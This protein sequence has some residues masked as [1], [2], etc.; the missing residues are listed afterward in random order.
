MA[1]LLPNGKQQFE[2][3]AGAPLVGGK[4]YTYDAGTT[5]PRA[6]YQDAAGTIP[7]TNPVILDARGEAT[8][9][10]N[11]TYKIILKDAS[12]VTIW[13]VDNVSAT[14]W[15]NDLNAALATVAAYSADM[16]NATDPAKGAAK[17]G[18][19]NRTVA[20]RLD[21][22]KSVSDFG[23]VPD[24]VTNWEAVGGT[25][26]NNMIAYAIAHGVYWPKGYY[27]TGI[28]LDS[29]MSGIKFHFEDGAIIGG[30]F[31]MISDASPASY[32][33]STISRSANVVTVVTSTPHGWATNQRIRVENVYNA[34]AGS[35]GFNGDDFTITVLNGTTFTYA[36]NGPNEAG[37][38]TSGA[39][40]SQRPIKNVVV[41]GRLTT[42]DRLGSINAKDCY[43]ERAWVKSDTT[44]HSAYPGTTCR[45]AHLYVGT[46]NLHIEE[47]IID[48][49][50]GANTDAALAIDGNA[51]N[52]KNIKIDFCWIKDSDYHGA[53]ITGGG[54]RFGFLR[55]DGFARGGYTGTLQ[56]SDGATQSQH[57]KGLWTNRVW[58]M[59]I[60]TLQTS[61]YPY[62][63]RGYELDQ[64]VIDETGST[65]F[66]KAN[67]G[68]KI[69]TWFASNVR[70]S[71]INFGDRD[72]DSVRCNVTVGLMEIRLDPAGLTAGE[73]AL[74]AVGA[75]GGSK[76]SIDTLRFIDLG[77]NQA[78]Y[79]ETTA[80]VSI[81]RVECINHTERALQARGRVTIGD[82]YIYNNG[83]T[84]ANPL[85]HFS[86]PAVAGS[87]IGNLFA[88]ASGAVSSRVLSS[89]N[90]SMNWKVRQLTTLNHRNAGGTCWLDGI[91]GC[92]I[93]AFHMV[94]PD[95]T[96]TGVGFNGAC[97]DSYL[98]PGR[99]E[100]FSKGFAKGTATFTRMTGV[101]LNG[102]GNT[103]PTDLANGSVV[104][105]GCNG[106]TL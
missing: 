38:V 11:G 97:S 61:Q 79:T 68:L 16:A 72:A 69:G 2:N 3:S 34:G 55:I 36:Q 15:Q 44:Q 98:G 30:V 52:P 66:N 6:T 54:H 82:I 1:T 88:N 32:A 14:P 103:T 4:L 63:S 71:G 95:S 21:D 84:V 77:T 25:N 50:S 67:H 33:I 48:D 40:V 91:V 43:I 70:R 56:D 49:A 57:V 51:W 31:H 24:G 62:G 28:N 60:G 83:G 81:R 39:Y 90:G 92:S 37:T 13:T 45:G 9:F 59:E 104:M 76:V 18:Y 19:S 7:N 47:L 96:N 93:D 99:V 58:D 80:D 89:D 46:D 106:V 22:F 100:G 75:S 86:N 102:N 20:A 26:W 27:A 65:Y 94:G 8:V 64:V 35:V 101:G 5:N 10:W 42:T 29:T 78:L 23:I 53:Y 74:R 85:V 105:V 41:T 12:D 17:V 73:F 87:E